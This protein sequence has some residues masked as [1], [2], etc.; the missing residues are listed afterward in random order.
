MCDKSSNSGTLNQAEKQAQ[1]NSY[2]PC[3]VREVS[4]QCIAGYFVIF[5]ACLKRH[6]LLFFFQY[7]LG[8]S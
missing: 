8:C 3:A 7:L 2:Q 5:A 1:P 4:T 6:H